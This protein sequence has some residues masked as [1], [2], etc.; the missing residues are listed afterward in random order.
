MSTPKHTEP[1]ILII[2]TSIVVYHIVRGKK[3]T[4]LGRNWRHHI[5]TPSMK[6]LRIKSIMGRELKKQVIAEL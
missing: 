1:I 3:M 6:A 4:Y 5:I 2:L